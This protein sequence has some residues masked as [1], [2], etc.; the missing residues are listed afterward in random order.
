MQRTIAFNNKGNFWTT[1][2]SY[3]SSCIGTVKDMMVTAPMVA[4]DNAP[5]IWRH[6]DT[7]SSNNTF[8]GIQSSSVVGL[9]FNDK[10]STNKQFKSFS[11]ESN[12]FSV[13]S[14]VSNTF[15]VN[16]TSGAI[17]IK[18]TNVGP[19]VNRGGINYAHIGQEQRITNSNVEFLGTYASTTSL[20][21]SPDISVEAAEQLG[22]TQT[23]FPNAVFVKLDNLQHSSL[24]SNEDVR[25]LVGQSNVLFFQTTE[26]NFGQ[27]LNEDRPFLYNG[28]LIF[29]T[30]FSTSI[31]T[32]LFL[33]YNE[34]N[35]E[36]PKGQ[37]ADSFVLLGSDDFE[38]YAF[39]VEYSPTQL[40]HSK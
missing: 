11:I 17:N 3:T 27:Q 38:I 26:G 28:G 10:P 8:Y 20:Y 23:E 29:E 24:S 1:R 40:D 13:D 30:N 32:P 14:F 9:T 35:G 5:L 4:F 31:G 33:G 15:T 39:N 36:A 37:F 12:D 21:N 18:Q 22:Y 6:D 19:V 16:G 34:V 7:A 25:L 2:Y